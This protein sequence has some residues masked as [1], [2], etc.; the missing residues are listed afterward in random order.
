MKDLDVILAYMEF[1]SYM[2]VINELKILSAIRVLIEFAAME[3]LI[4][5]SSIFCSITLNPSIY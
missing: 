4:V 2:E 5:Y 1:L 3:D